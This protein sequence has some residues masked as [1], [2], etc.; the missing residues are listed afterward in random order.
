MDITGADLSKVKKTFDLPE[1]VEAPVRKG[2]V[3][4]YAVYMLEDKTIGKTKILFD[5]NVEEAGIRDYIKKI[6]FCYLL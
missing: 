1:S 5:E 3:A 6:T 4:G 2:D